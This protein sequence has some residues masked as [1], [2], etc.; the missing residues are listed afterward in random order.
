[1]VYVVFYSDVDSF[2]ESASPYGLLGPLVERAVE[3]VRKRGLKP[4]L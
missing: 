3:E 2:P 1:M 4:I